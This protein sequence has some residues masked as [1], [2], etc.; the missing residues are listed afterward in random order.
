M[1]TQVRITASTKVS[2]LVRYVEESLATAKA[3]SAEA[4]AA[5]VRI[6]GLYLTFAKSHDL[7]IQETRAEVEHLSV[8]AREASAQDVLASAIAAAKP[9]PKAPQGK[10]DTVAIQVPRA[11]RDAL[12]SLGIDGN[13]AAIIA[14]LIEGYTTRQGAPVP[15]RESLTTAIAA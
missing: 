7:S 15:E 2:T 5:K 4:R 12:R 10:G 11:T 14:A 9:A 13:D 3:H 1:A 6:G 8:K